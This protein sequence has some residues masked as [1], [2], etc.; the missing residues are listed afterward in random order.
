MFCVLIP[1]YLYPPVVDYRQ[2][3]SR[4]SSRE[5]TLRKWLRTWTI[6]QSAQNQLFFSVPR[7]VSSV[8]ITLPGHRRIDSHVD[9]VQ[10]IGQL[11]WLLE[12]AD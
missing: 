12:L 6:T 11:S 9:D 5:A 7:P 10:T 3:P 4:P 8:I 1:E 2:A